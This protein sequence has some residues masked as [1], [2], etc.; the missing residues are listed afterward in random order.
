MTWK[1][2]LPALLTL[3]AALTRC[4][5]DPCSSAA[6]VLAKCAPSGEVLSLDAGMTPACEGAYLCTSQCA[7][8]VTCSQITD[9]DPAYTTCV[10]QCYAE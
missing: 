1:I 7:N 4:G 8:E 2:A 6:D 9:N 5:D 3:A 10:T